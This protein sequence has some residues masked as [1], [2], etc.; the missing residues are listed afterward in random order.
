MTLTIEKGA[1]RYAALLALAERAVAHHEK[2][3]VT[4]IHILF[5][6]PSES[7][8]AKYNVA[9]ARMADMLRIFTT[10]PPDSSLQYPGLTAGDIQGHAD[11]QEVLEVTPER[12]VAVYVLSW[13]L[14]AGEEVK[15][16]DMVNAA[17]HLYPAAWM[18]WRGELS[19]PTP[20]RDLLQWIWQQCETRTEAL[21][22]I[23]RNAAALCRQALAL[24]R[25]M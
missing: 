3:V 6:E 17:W 14:K 11:T 10:A 2:C 18:M 1:D 22:L 8:G 25:A 12:L 4:G 13:A 5:P 9:V 20:L 15:A 16:R 19:A 24:S 23:E 21:A 7:M